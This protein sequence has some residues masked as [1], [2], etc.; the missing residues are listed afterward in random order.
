MGDRFGTG[1]LAVHMISPR[2][3]IRGRL[4]KNGVC[5]GVNFSLDRSGDAFQ[6]IQRNTAA[7]WADLERSFASD[8]T[9]T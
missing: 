9:A 3:K 6:V 1:F 5:L 4:V 8:Q 7:A 2:V